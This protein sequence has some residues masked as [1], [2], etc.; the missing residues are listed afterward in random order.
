MKRLL[1]LLLPAAATVIALT[2]ISV[3]AASASWEG[4]CEKCTKISGPNETLDITSTENMSGKGVC[5][6]LWKYNGGTNYNVE[7]EVCGAEATLAV[8][9]IPSTITG[10]G[11]GEAW[12][13]EF[14]YRLLLFQWIQ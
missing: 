7:Q 9:K 6:I 10:H 12:F 4:G 13:R 5:A 11:E 3:P 14:T 2:C 1:S 8:A